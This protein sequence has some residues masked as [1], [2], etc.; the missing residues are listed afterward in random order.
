MSA[1]SQFIKENTL[2]VVSDPAGPDGDYG[3]IT[4]S[5]GSQII[6]HI[7]ALP[8]PS[9][10]RGILWATDIPGPLGAYVEAHPNHRSG[11]VARTWADMV[12][13]LLPAIVGEL[14]PDVRL[15]V[16]MSTKRL[17]WPGGHIT[18]L[19]TW[20]NVDGLRGLRL[21][22]V[23]CP[24]WDDENILGWMKTTVCR[25]NPSGRFGIIR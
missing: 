2:Q 1:E 20:S 15:L 13:N 18:H 8:L 3:S 22:A 17:L 11:V 14:K 10:G 12:D 4:I 24:S 19:R 16:H 7:P 25:T 9:R 6:G 5:R 23:W 21:D